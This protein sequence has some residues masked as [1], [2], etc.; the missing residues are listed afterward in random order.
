[1]FKSDAWGRLGDGREEEEGMRSGRERRIQ[2]EGEG[3]GWRAK[4]GGWREGGGWKVEGG[5]RREESGGRRA[6]AGV[7]GSEQQEGTSSK[8]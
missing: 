2:E 4:G 1:V 3:G 7:E 5:K 6:E 8:K